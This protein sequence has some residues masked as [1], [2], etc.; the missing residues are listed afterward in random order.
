MRCAHWSWIIGGRFI[1]VIAFIFPVR[2][3]EVLIGRVIVW[4][5]WRPMV[6]M[7]C[8]PILESETRYEAW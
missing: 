5:Q 8:R 2:R 6:E 7:I 3:S 4:V 1:W